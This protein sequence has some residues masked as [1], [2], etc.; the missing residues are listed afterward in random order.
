M[1]V[2]AAIGG[3]IAFQRFAQESPVPSNEDLAPEQR[4]IPGTSGLAGLAPKPAGGSGDNLGGSPGSPGTPAGGSVGGAGANPLAQFAARLGAAPAN[5]FGGPAGNPLPGSPP[6]PK[7]PPNQP[8]AFNAFRAGDSPL[9]PDGLPAWGKGKDPQGWLPFSQ[10]NRINEPFWPGEYVWL[11]SELPANPQDY[12]LMLLNTTYDFEI[13]LNATR[14]YRHGEMDR[15]NFRLEGTKPLFVHLPPHNRE[16]VLYMRIFTP[17][18]NAQLGTITIGLLAPLQLEL[19]KNG[20]F[21]LAAI[22]LF[23]FIGTIALVIHIT[24][25]ESPGNLYFALFS[26]LIAFKMLL[27]IESMELLFDFS[28][29]AYYLDEP[30]TAAML[31]TFI[32]YFLFVIRPPFASW[33]RLLGKL[34]PFVGILFPLCKKF[35]PDLLITLS[36]YLSAAYVVIFSLACL[37]SLFLLYP[38]LFAQRENNEAR[39]FSYGFSVFFLINLI[40]VPLRAINS[41]YPSLFPVWALETGDIVNVSLR[42]SVFCLVLYFGWNLVRVAASVFRQNRRQA[43][44]LQEQNLALQKVDKLK[45]DFLANTSH[46][47][48]TPLHGIIGLSESLLDGAAG[49]LSERAAHNISMIITSGKR[50]ASLVNDILDFSKLKHEEIVLKR[51]AVDLRQTAEMVLLMLQP[52]LRSKTLQLENAIPDGCFVDADEDRM[53]QIMYN[54]IGNAIKFTEQGSVRLTASL[55]GADWEIRIAD[56]GIGIPEDKQVVIFESFAQADGSIS[57][58]FGGTGLGLSITKQLIELHGGGIG[59]QSVVGQGTTFFFRLPR[60]DAEE[61]ALAQTAAAGNTA[62]SAMTIAAAMAESAPLLP[63]GLAPQVPFESVAAS[64]DEAISAT[65]RPCLLIVDDDP[66]N[67]Q[68]MENYLSAEPYRLVFAPS[69]AQALNLMEG[70][71]RPSLIV[72]DVMMPHMSGYELCRILRSDVAT[73][74]QLPIL[75]LT[76]KNLPSDLVDGFNSGANDYLNKP[77]S[78]QELLARVKLHLQLSQWNATLENKVQERTEAIQNLLDYTGQ[79]FLSIAADLRIMPEYSIESERLLGK[80]LAGRRLVECLYSEDSEARTFMEELLT[81][82]FAEE[83]EARAEVLLSLLPDELSLNSRSIHLQ[84]KKIHG[85]AGAPERLMVILTDLSEQRRLQDTMEKERKILQMVVRVV[86]HYKEFRQLVADYRS[87]Y[88]QGVREL[89]ESGL[90]V[91]DQCIE[92]LRETHTMKGNFAQFDFLFT[93]EQL[94]EFENRLVEW[95]VRLVGEE[96]GAVANFFQEW[97]SQVDVHRWL[98]SDLQAL[99]D[100]LGEGLPFDTDTV[101]IRKSS[102][103]RIE[104]IVTALLPASEALPVIG[105]LKKLTF[106]PFRD[107]LNLYP[108]YVDRVAVRLS[109]K[110]YPLNVVGGDTLV[111]HDYYTPF[112]RTLSHIFTN[113]LDHGLESPGDRASVGKDARGTITCEIVERD[114]ELEIVIANDGRPIDVRQIRQTVLERGLA[115]AEVF[116]SLSESEQLGHIFAESFST[117]ERVSVAS[118]RGM[119]L[120]AVKKAV[121]QLQGSVRVVNG[122]AAGFA[123]VSGGQGVAFI[124]TLPLVF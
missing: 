35:L 83:D 29:W 51:K 88:R 31:Y 103:A 84:Y 123:G 71:L 94:H 118:G 68:V 77:V 82:M 99:N 52:M 34:V 106:L 98:N 72:T 65:E 90:P 25:R 91:I 86:T 41:A 111:D 9:D 30:L 81:S 79:G 17:V 22:M 47:L 10:L 12:Y 73:R 122:D 116:D 107:L 120:S 109:K 14:I 39:W 58:E 3:P 44:L 2:A 45:D 110:V 70:G 46:E 87:Y 76:A 102:L 59:V 4:Q 117:K 95:H 23:Y 66:I 74:N 100:V 11:R 49:S 1:I 93:V 85:V 16:A 56:T 27:G 124:F 96:D 63:T 15:D 60:A 104:R 97:V 6:P 24:N 50:L 112:T 69:A 75:L 53:Q 40:G 21:D 26:V 92:L 62:A 101:Q 108:E 36:P 20:L 38:S 8:V 33:I 89:F 113:M 78:R 42:I 54:L 57:R 61:D 119:G 13:Y 19:I 37:A 7:S 67:L 114:A 121:E 55:S 64:I 48:R 28:A 80:E 43:E 5:E 105:E 115:T 18:K 32:Q